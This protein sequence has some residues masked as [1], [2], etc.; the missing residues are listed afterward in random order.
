MQSSDKILQ[1]S[2]CIYVCVC[3]RE[4]IIFIRHFFRANAN[5]HHQKKTNYHSLFFIICLNYFFG[6]S[7]LA[8]LLPGKCQL[9]KKR[10]FA[11]FPFFFFLS[12]VPTT[13]KTPTTTTTKLNFSTKYLLIDYKK[14]IKKDEKKIYEKIN[15]FV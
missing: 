1:F 15:L 4:S 7:Q 14:R 13:T 12:R 11:Y 2:D 9:N 10:L 8:H 5:N 6:S 3:V